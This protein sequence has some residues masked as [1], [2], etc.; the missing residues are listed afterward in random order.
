MLAAYAPKSIASNGEILVKS[1]L[2]VDHLPSSKA[3]IFALGDVAKTSGPK[4]GR[5]GMVQGEVVLNNIIRLIKNQQGLENYEP[6][7][8]EGAL[9]L[10]MGEHNQIM[11]LQTGD[12]ELLEV[13]KEMADEDVSAAEV[14]ER[15]HAELP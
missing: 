3:N 1:T 13:M 9:Q 14:W 6:M 15:C 4:Q 8:F 2:Q 5:A 10:T 7:A 12:Y 11:Y